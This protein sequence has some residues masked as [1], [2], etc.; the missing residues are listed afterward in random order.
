MIDIDEL[1]ARAEELEQ[2]PRRVLA[3]AADRFA[4]RLTFAASL[5]GDCAVID[6]IGRAS[7]PI[8]I[9]TPIPASFPKPTR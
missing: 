5:P 9:F 7:L 1:K 4:P 6:L 2:S 3:W 8:D